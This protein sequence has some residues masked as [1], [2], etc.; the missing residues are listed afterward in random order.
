MIF[1][2]KAL[3]RPIL[4]DFPISFSIKSVGVPYF[5]TILK[6]LASGVPSLTYNSPSFV[7]IIFNSL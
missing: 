6:I 4:K 2:F 5:E 3:L 1:C 7:R